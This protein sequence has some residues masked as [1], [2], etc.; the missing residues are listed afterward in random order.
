MWR[1]SQASYCK[2]SSGH[3]ESCETKYKMRKLFL[4]LALNKLHASFRT[5][6]KMKR[7]FKC[8]NLVVLMFH[9][10]GKML[11]SKMQLL[12]QISHF[13]SNML[14]KIILKV[15]FNLINGKYVSNLILAFL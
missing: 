3:L 4:C 6:K 10:V 2:R 8:Q 14:I 9:K 1:K 15:E 13:Y 7:C 5:N 12:Q 11:N